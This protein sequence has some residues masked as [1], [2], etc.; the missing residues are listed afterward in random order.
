MNS[1]IKSPNVT[2]FILGAYMM[3][4]VK[5]IC[6]VSG[7]TITRLTSKSY[8]NPMPK[9]LIIK[10][11]VMPALDGTAIN[12]A[13]LVNMEIPIAISSSNNTGAYFL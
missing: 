4:V 2:H 9:L 8:N 3:F 12:N 5:V 11:A 6:M 13:N 10:A 7:I 1:K